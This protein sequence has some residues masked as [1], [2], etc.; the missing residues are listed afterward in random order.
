MRATQPQT[1]GLARKQGV[2]QNGRMNTPV[3][4]TISV[5][6]QLQPSL[7][8]AFGPHRHEI[9][10][11][12]RDRQVVYDILESRVGT[13]PPG[14]LQ[15]PSY[16]PAQSVDAESFRNT[17]RGIRTTRHGDNLDIP[18]RATPGL[19]RQLLL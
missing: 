13:R 7:D 6:P 10:T 14:R 3:R 1:L 12:Q 9:T 5:E 19:L 16:E 15:A 2:L 8:I 11:A 17:S 18:P 4:P